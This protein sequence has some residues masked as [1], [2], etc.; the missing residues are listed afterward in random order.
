MYA[1]QPISNHSNNRSLFST[2]SEITVSQRLTIPARGQLS[3]EDQGEIGFCFK[4]YWYYSLLNRG[5]GSHERFLKN[6]P[7]HKIWRESKMVCLKVLTVLM[8][9]LF[10]RVKAALH[11]LDGMTHPIITV[12]EYCDQWSSLPLSPLLSHWMF[13]CSVQQIEHNLHWAIMQ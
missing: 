7:E 1:N 5:I 8:C 10:E 12:D 6:T 4:L 13:H 2:Q 9:L 3:F 11:S